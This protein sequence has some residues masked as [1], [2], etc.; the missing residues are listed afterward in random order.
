MLNGGP[1]ASA[2]EFGKDNAVRV[3]LPCN[4]AGGGY[5][6]TLRSK[7]GGDLRF[8]GFRVTRSICPEIAA[9]RAVLA[10]LGRVRSYAIDGGKLVLSLDGGGTM[11]W[12][13]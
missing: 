4:T 11:T 7:A 6:A 8:E 12:G 1:S 10:Q 3:K 13:D 9:E 5:V 2:I